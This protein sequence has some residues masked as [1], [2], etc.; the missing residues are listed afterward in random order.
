[1]SEASAPI[2]PAKAKGIETVVETITP[3][4][5]REYLKKNTNNYRTIKRSVIRSYAEDIKNGRWELN[6]EPI[7]F[8]KNGILKNGQHRLAAIV[9]A[10]K[11][12]DI[13]VVR[14]VDDS[15]SKYDL[16]KKRTDTDILNAEGFECD[17]TLIAAANIV[18]N[19]FSGVRS[20]TSVQEY[21]RKNY[22]ELC[23]AM[24]VACTGSKAKNKNA[25]SICASY[26]MLRTKS[27]PCYEVELFFRIM[28]E[29]GYVNADGYE[30]S[31]AVVAKHQI[32][33]RGP[34]NTGGYQ[35]QRER[36]EIL[37]MAMKDF[38]AGKKRELKYRIKEPFEFSTLLAKVRK[39]D[40]LD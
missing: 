6:G 13:L 4:K 20:G 33:D 27:M 22:A 34:G 38:H 11:P 25:P 16:G 7:V 8:G 19:R 37:I 28:N 26:L 23:R 9:L 12:A 3:A 15:I 29:Y 5:A 30:P 14:G 1:M 2:I 32:D 35:L 10:N 18:V 39:E 24:R 31:P 17:A 36:L 40:G 21:A